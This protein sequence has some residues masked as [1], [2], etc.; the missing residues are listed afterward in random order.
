MEVILQEDMP[1][2]GK[3][4]TVVKVT[5]GYARNFLMPQG[6]AL[7]ADPA[8]L[9]MVEHQRVVA[10]AREAKLRAE[11]EKNA[12]RLGACRL[13]FQ[14]EAGPEGKLFGAITQH[15][16]LKELKAVNGV[17]V[18]RR[19]LRL[20]EPIKQIGEYT[21]EIRLHPLVVAQVTVIVEAK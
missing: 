3:A 19:Q 17:P 6:K 16:L 10:Q 18:D 13:R 11:A 7:P 21:V 5:D 4:G 9:R 8:N 12:A 1:S 15:D 2:L 20:A 14:R